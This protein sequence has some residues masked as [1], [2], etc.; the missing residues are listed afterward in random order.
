MPYTVQRKLTI[1]FE[2]AKG[3]QGEVETRLDVPLKAIF[4]VQ[5][6]MQTQGEQS[7]G[8]AAKVFA[9]SA[10]LS[11][12]LVEEGGAPIPATPE[13]MASLPVGLQAAILAAW[14]KEVGNVPTPLAGPSANGRSERAPQES[15]SPGS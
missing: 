12:N 5:E 13:G 1:R 9:E 15:R 14:A 3:E 10:L 2:G 11:W 4:A 8:G 6:T 7:F